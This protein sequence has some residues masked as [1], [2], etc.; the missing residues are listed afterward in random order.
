VHADRL[1]NGPV[2]SGDG[3]RF[4]GRGFFIV[5]RANYTQFSEETGIDLIAKPDL[6]SNPHIALLIAALFWYNRG[7]D[8]IA[9][10]EDITAIRKII[11][12]DNIGLQVSRD[13]T[14]DAKKLLTNKAQR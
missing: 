4:R 10:K 7:L 2:D 12:G 14:A 1:G 6:A 9:D 13:Y 8:E 11:S 5:G 3:W